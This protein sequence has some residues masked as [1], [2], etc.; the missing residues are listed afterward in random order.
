MKKV[1]RIGCIIADNDEYAPMR[2]IIKKYNPCRRDVL[3]REGHVFSLKNEDR[4][5]NIH[6]VLCGVGKVNA[7]A[8]AAY[9]AQEGCDMIFNFGLS[10]GISGIKRGELTVGTEYIEHDFDL[11]L[12]GYAVCEKPL[13][14][15]VYKSDSTLL[16]IITEI[17][18]EIKK[19]VIVSGDCFISNEEKKTFLKETFNAMSC[20]M[21]SAA[22]AYV[23]ERAEI[24][25]VAIRKISDDAGDDAKN[26]YTE[27]NNK[28]ETV[29]TQV[30]I[31]LVQRLFE[32]NILWK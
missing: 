20:D 4:E 18:P 31:S 10:G 21:E 23:C 27:M 32:Q 8:V 26:S 9:L 3:K 6:S 16:D 25:F 11:T 28:R 24:P 5:I 12:L 30:F 22:I 1:L 29:L 15:Y 13:Q 19:G 14:N 7:T 2:D 17:Y